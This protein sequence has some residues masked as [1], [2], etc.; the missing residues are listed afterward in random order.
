ML[1]VTYLSIFI[2]YTAFYL[3]FYLFG[4]FIISR[5]F[6]FTKEGRSKE[7]LFTKT[8]YLAPFFG[9]LILGNLLIIL[10]IFTPLN[11]IYVNIFL[12]LLPFLSL[13]KFRFHFLVPLLIE[14]SFLI[15]LILLHLKFQLLNLILKVF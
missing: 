15:F 4:K 3:Y 13:K 11:N 7:L 12:I 10:N 2:K 9:L 8:E 14:N 6:K 5:I 1:I